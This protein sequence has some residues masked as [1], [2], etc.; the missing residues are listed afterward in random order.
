M[1][2][3]QDLYNS[4]QQLINDWIDKHQNISQNQTC[5][6]KSHHHCLVVYCWSDPLQL[7]ESQQNHYIWEVCSGNLWDALK[8]AMPTEGIGQQKGLDSS[9]WQCLTTLYITKTSKVEWIWL[10]SF[11]SSTIFIWPL[12]SQLP[13]LQASGQF[14]FFFGRE[15]TSTTS[16]RQITLSRIYQILSTDFYAPGIHLFHIDKNML[17]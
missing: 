5:T 7:S 10:W 13:L 3:K 6:K 11:A 4:W 9:P 1:W 2:Q 17:M 8:T 14:F 15:N 12:A 16:R